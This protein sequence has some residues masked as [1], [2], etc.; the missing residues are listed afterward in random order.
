MVL[1]FFRYNDYHFLEYN[2]YGDT[3]LHMAT[4]EGDIQRVKALIKMGAQTRKTTTIN[5]RNQIFSNATTIH[6]AILRKHPEIIGMM[7]QA[8][9]SGSALE[10]KCK[11]VSE[12]SENANDWTTLQLAMYMERQWADEKTKLVNNKLKIY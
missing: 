8:E 11:A 2:S 3:L 1:L 10:V 9:D 7:L 4:H 12:R 6:V 5:I